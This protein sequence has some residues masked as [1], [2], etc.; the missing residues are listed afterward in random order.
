MGKIDLN[1]T[2][3]HLKKTHKRLKKLT[4]KGKLKKHVRDGVNSIYIR[5]KK[6][7][8]KRRQNVRFNVLLFLFFFR[9]NMI[10]LRIVWL[11]KRKKMKMI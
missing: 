4:K 6:D 5:K 10:G 7:L 8:I 2:R 3:N 1:P 11:Y 9:L